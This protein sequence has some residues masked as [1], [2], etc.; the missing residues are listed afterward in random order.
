ML[1]AMAMCDALH[2]A[3]VEPKDIPPGAFAPGG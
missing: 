3:Y 2:H 1:G